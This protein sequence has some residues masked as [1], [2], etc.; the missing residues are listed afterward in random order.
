MEKDEY[1]VTSNVILNEQYKYI[2]NTHRLYTETEHITDP[3]VF[4]VI[5]QPMVWVLEGEYSP[6]MKCL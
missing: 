4:A 5:L 3:D 6:V 2:L 1:D